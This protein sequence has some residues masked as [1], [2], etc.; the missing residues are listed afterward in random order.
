MRFEWSGEDRTTTHVSPPGPVRWRVSTLVEECVCIVRV[1][2]EA[3][4]QTVFVSSLSPD[5]YNR[6]YWRS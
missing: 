2:A 6:L 5:A 1:S 3:V 4:A